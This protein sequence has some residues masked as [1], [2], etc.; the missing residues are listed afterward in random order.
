MPNLTLHMIVKN[1]EST[2]PVCLKSIKDFVD[3]IVIVDTGSTDQTVAIAQ[4]FGAQVEHFEWVNDFSAA[5]NYALSHVKT[6]WAMWLDADDMVINPQGISDLLEHAR[7]N[8]A[9]SIYTNYQQEASCYQKRMHLFKP[10]NYQWEGAVHENPMPK[11]SALAQA[12]ISDILVVHRKPAERGPQAAKQY[13]EILEQKD[14]ENWLGLAESYKYLYHT[15]DSPDK[16]SDYRD[17]ADFYYWKALSHPEINDWTR[18]YCHFQIAWFNLYRSSNESKW[19]DIAIR[20]AQA[21]VALNPERAE[22]WGILGLCWKTVERYDR[23]T[24]AFETALGCQLPDSVNG[25]VFPAYYGEIPQKALEEIK[26]KVDAQREPLIITPL[27]KTL[28]LP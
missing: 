4:S 9:D 11:N 16:R 6:P 25:L 24:E 12:L 20:N 13:L 28:I 19:F 27:P 3:H 18:Y 7:K 17:Q 14:P 8:R 10:K 22:G 15:P 21:C 2:L 23:A 5:R 26:K 1:E